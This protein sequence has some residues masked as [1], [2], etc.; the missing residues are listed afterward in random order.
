MLITYPYCL[1][2]YPPKKMAIFKIC[3]LL[4][5]EDFLIMYITCCRCLN[6]V[7]SSDL[8]FLTTADTRLQALKAWPLVKN[9]KKVFS[10]L[11]CL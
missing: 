11:K 4:A 2:K 1:R 8:W 10:M 7:L 5:L 3:Y 9:I 6:P